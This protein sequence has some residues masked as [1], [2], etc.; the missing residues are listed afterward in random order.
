MAKQCFLDR[1]KSYGLIVAAFVLAFIMLRYLELIEFPAQNFTALFVFN[2]NFLGQQKEETPVLYNSTQNETVQWPSMQATALTVDEVQSKINRIKSQ[3]IKGNSKCTSVHN[4]LY[5]AWRSSSNQSVDTRA[6]DFNKFNFASSCGALYNDELVKPL[7]WSQLVSLWEQEYL[8]S[9]HVNDSQDIAS[10]STST[11]ELITPV[12]INGSLVM[13]SE[14]K[15]KI[16]LFNVRKEP[17][18]QGGDLINV[19]LVSDAP[20]A[21]IAADVLD[22]RNG[23]YTAI[24]VLPWCGKVKVM[25][26]IAHQR[27]KFRLM[28]YIQRVFKTTYWFAGNFHSPNASEYTPCLPHPYIPGHAGNDVCNLTAMLGSPYFCGRPIKTE[29]LNCSDFISTKRLNDF[30]NLALSETETWLLHTPREKRPFFISNNISITVVPA[31]AS[32]ETVLSFSRLK[33]NERK[34]SLSFKDNNSF[35]FFYLGEWRPLT[36][37]LPKLNSSQLRECLADT[38]VIFLGDSNSR[39]QYDILSGLVGCQEKMKRNSG[40]WHAP[41]LCESENNSISISYLPHSFPFFGST[42]EELPT[43]HVFSE[44]RFLDSVP[45]DA[46]YIIHFHHFLHLAPFHLGH[47]EHR[48]K[49]IR[50]ALKRL[51][52]RNPHVIFLYQSAHSVYIRQTMNGIFYVE[53]QRRILEGLGDRVMF[54]FTWPMTIALDNNEVHPHIADKFTKLYMGHIC[55]RAKL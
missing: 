48:L 37:D 43:E 30:S 6:D 35:G 52:D 20:K 1:R 32:N 44:T 10:A 3:T 8:S 24:T 47:M 40:V 23:T 28:F 25:A 34:L 13:G 33:C 54:V 15:F 21:S 55:G 26:A 49:L 53:L 50:E 45:A 4:D 51:L 9:P 18:V 31:Q 46:K 11:I 42:G 36:C 39:A 19:W 22:H 29:F 38:K 7:P 14:V 41:L 17:R 5:L 12:G 27:E 2:N 16:T